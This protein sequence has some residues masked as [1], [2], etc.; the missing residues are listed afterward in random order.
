V[1]HEEDCGWSFAGPSGQGDKMG[2]SVGPC[3]SCMAETERYLRLY[4]ILVL[5]GQCR[6][7]PRLALALLLC[8]V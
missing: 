5:R 7:L 3:S 4:S 1:F 2:R 6:S 8:C